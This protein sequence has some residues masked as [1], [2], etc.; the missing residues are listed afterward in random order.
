MTNIQLDHIGQDGI[1][2]LEDLAHIK[3]LVLERVREGGTLV[4]NADDAHVMRLMD[5]PRVRKLPREIRLFSA[6]PNH[7]NVRRHLARGGTAYFPRRGWIVE[8]AVAAEQSLVE[9]ASIP[10]V[11]RPQPGT[12]QPVPRRPGIRPHRL[13]AQSGRLRSGGADERTL[14][15]PPRDGGRWRPR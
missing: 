6:Y 5:H 15:G 2:T 7:V 13:R 12:R 14:A 10:A 11:P 9:I 8:G 3:S 4:L 1:E